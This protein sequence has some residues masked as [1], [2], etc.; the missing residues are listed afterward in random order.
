MT[1][2]RAE[3]SALLTEAEQQVAYARACINGYKRHDALAHSTFALA[4]LELAKAKALDVRW[5][6][7]GPEVEAQVAEGLEPGSGGTEVIV[8][9]DGRVSP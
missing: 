3:K 9:P 6:Q 5:D 4:L 1:V 2:N 7:G 8:E